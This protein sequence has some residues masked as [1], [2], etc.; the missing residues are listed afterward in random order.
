MLAS[1]RLFR[2]LV[3]SLA[4]AAH[5]R[6]YAADYRRAPEARCPAAIDDAVA[7]YRAL[8]ES[9]CAPE[10][11]AVAG[12]SAGGGL[13]LTMAVALR[14]AGLPQPA[15]LA[16]ISPWTDLT[17]SGDSFT[18]KVRADPVLRPSLLTAN[19]DHYRGELPASDPR[20]SPLFADLSGLPPLYIQ[21]TED[22]LLFS[23]SLRLARRARAAG[24]EVELE[25]QGDRLF[26]VFQAFPGLLPEA[27]AALRS[28]AAF[29]GERFS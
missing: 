20:C 16:A 29:V 5:A 11:L 24:V 14:D 8:L 26:H 12:D 18:Q 2:P 22:D 7:C 9:G 28:V 6:V 3:A 15:A 10:R 19:A 27:E 17:H 25:I 1:P 21:A 4:H 23:D 13:A